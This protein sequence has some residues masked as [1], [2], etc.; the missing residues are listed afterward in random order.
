MNKQTGTDGF[1]TLLNTPTG[2]D[3]LDIYEYVTTDGC[4]V[5]PTPTKL[6]LYPKFTPEIFLDDTYIN[7]STDITGPWKVY[8][9]DETTTASY[10]GNV[11]CIKMCLLY[12]MIMISTTVIIIK[13]LWGTGGTSTVPVRYGHHETPR[14]KQ[15]AMIHS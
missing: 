4:W 15:T 7:I 5:P 14:P 3:T 11:G 8:G 9:R 10:K 2:G 13:C 1:L 6:G 12:S